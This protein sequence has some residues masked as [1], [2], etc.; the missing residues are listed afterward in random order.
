MQTFHILNQFS[1]TLKHV[2]FEVGLFFI[3]LKF[4][5]SITMLPTAFSQQHVELSAVCDY[6]QTVFKQRWYIKE[7]FSFLRCLYVQL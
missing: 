5:I 2:H 6:L 4:C 3:K 1:I 7:E